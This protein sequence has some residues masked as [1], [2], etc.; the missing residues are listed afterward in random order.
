M[1]QD[2]VSIVSIASRRARTA[3]K[4]VSLDGVDGDPDG[5]V[6]LRRACH[7]RL[8]ALWLAA[9]DDV[10]QAEQERERLARQSWAG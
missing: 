9:I 2:T 1:R 7:E 6:A 8:F 4:G 5:E 3:A 10:A